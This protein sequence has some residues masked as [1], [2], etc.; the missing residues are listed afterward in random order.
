[1]DE[2]QNFT[3]TDALTFMGEVSSGLKTSSDVP[4]VLAGGGTCYAFCSLENPRKRDDW[5][6]DGYRWRHT[7]KAKIKINN[8]VI[9]K[10]YFSVFSA[11]KIYTSNFRRISHECDEY[12]HIVIVYYKGDSSVAGNFPHGNRR[13][14]SKPF[15]RTCPSVLLSCKY[16]KGA[17][18][19]IYHSMIK[20]T[21]NENDCAI[22][23]QLS[24][25]RDILQVAN[26]KKYMRK[27]RRLTL[28]A[29]RELQ[30]EDVEKFIIDI[31]C[32]D[33]SLCAVV[34]QEERCHKINSLLSRLPL[35]DGTTLTYCL[36]SHFKDYNINV[37]LCEHQDSII[38]HL[39][40]FIHHSKST[41]NL[42]SI[43]EIANKKIP[44]LSLQ[45]IILEKNDEHLW[46]T[47]QKTYFDFSPFISVI[48]KLKMWDDNPCD[49]IDDL[50]CTAKHLHN[51]SLYYR[52][53][54]KNLHSKM[55]KHGK[56][57]I[58]DKF[59]GLLDLMQDDVLLCCTPTFE[60]ATA[61]VQKAF[62]TNRNA[63]K[64]NYNPLELARNIIDR[65]GIEFKSTTGIFLITDEISVWTVK[66]FPV[67]TCHCNFPPPCHHII[68]AKYSIGIPFPKPTLMKQSQ[69]KRKK[70]SH[71]F[72][73][74]GKII[75]EIFESEN[76]DTGKD[77]ESVLIE[78]AP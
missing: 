12:P 41:I 40:F 6:A 42:E 46:M 9:R 29:I 35:P 27:K 5:K 66:L 34:Y 8:T 56:Y 74:N 73:P 48:E 78:K 38:I 26:V 28:S 22:G 31:S 55:N 21:S 25:P 68:A 23:T 76:D 32:Q 53:S 15:I 4:I 3:A 52:S 65:N 50:Q 67:E 64:L 49:A 75:V 13:C 37:L 77:D 71:D 17:P 18:S 70:L 59:T 24:L 58:N 45:N 7:G 10:T 19:T 60:E 16:A 47:T 61:Y 1:M 63:D 33:D 20:S 44:K 62:S 69:F 30:N 2:V 39:L 43:W 11:P 54:A 36:C 14:G 72:Q 51:L 57:R